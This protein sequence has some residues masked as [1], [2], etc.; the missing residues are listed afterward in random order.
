MSPFV[1]VLLSQ[2]CTYK[3]VR[4]CVSMYVY[5]CVCV[6]VFVCIVVCSG[7]LQTF[8]VETVRSLERKEAR[9]WMEGEGGGRGQ[10]RQD[11]L[12][13]GEDSRGSVCFCGW[14]FRNIR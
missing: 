4:V 8:P 13:M 5:V 14:S 7:P 12:W 11:E 9:V 6:C 10:V 1:S 2:R 3:C